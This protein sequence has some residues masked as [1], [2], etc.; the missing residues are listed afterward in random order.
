MPDLL[1]N[2]DLAVDA[3]KIR[4]IL[5]LFFLKDLNCDL[6]TQII[7]ISKDSYKYG[8]VEE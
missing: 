8:N 3:L 5:Y 2:G 4:M 7:V 6:K 1:E